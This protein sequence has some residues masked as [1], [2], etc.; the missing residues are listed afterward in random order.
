M[1]QQLEADGIGILN[2]VDVKKTFPAG[3]FCNNYSGGKAA[4]WTWGWSASILP[5]MDEAVI[6]DQLNFA[7]LPGDNPN[8]FPPTVSSFPGP[9][10]NIIPTFLC[11]STNHINTNSRTAQRISLYNTIQS[12]LPPKYQNGSGMETGASDY[13][14]ISGPD[15]GTIINP[16]TGYVWPSSNNDG[17]GVLL[18][19]HIYQN[20][21]SATQISLTVSPRQITDGLSQTM[22]VGELIGRGFDQTHAWV[23]GSWADGN[24]IFAIVDVINGSG[25]G[26]GG[27]NPNAQ[28]TP[29]LLPSSS[30][31]TTW[32]PAK[33][34]LSDHP[35]GAQALICDGSVHFLADTTDVFVLCFLATRA[36]NEMIPADVLGD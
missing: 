11:P 34:L 6:Y 7:F 2:Y 13:G 30:W 1:C 9:T 16:L 26:G 12:S 27:A 36:G 25:T 22:I 17:S 21:P 4:P 8:A 14:G 35:G 28:P 3:K 19:L 29:W 15:T 10:Q 31:P 18:N 33:I 20:N 23:R 32:G 24:N 5:Y